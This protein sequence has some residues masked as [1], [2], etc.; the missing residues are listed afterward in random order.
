VKENKVK[1][2]VIQRGKFAMSKKEKQCKSFD[3]RCS[4]SNFL[5]QKLFNK[6]EAEY[7][8]QYACTLTCTYGEDNATF[9][10]IVPSEL[11]TLQM[12]DSIFTLIKDYVNEKKA[13]KKLEIQ[14][15]TNSLQVLQLGQKTK[16]DMQKE[17]ISVLSDGIDDVEAFETTS[18]VNQNWFF[19]ESDLSNRDVFHFGVIISSVN[20]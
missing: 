2:K 17:L 9:V 1:T 19:Q 18:W 15:S 7:K 16:D 13:S 8:K 14:Q 3:E 6:E 5:I 4:K 10:L 20:S 12:Q 11:E